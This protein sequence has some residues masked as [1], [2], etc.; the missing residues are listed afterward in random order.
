MNTDLVAIGLSLLLIVLWTWLS[1]RLMH[2]KLDRVLDILSKFAE[3]EKSS[4][5]PNSVQADE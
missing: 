1:L 2:R 4:G 5:S 3:K